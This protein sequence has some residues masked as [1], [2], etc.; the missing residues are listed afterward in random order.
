MQQD[1]ISVIVPCYN[2]EKYIDD[3]FKSLEN[4]TYQNIEVIFVNDGSKDGTF[5]KIKKFCEG[6]KKFRYIDKP[7]GGVGSA[8]NVGISEAKGKF[9]YFCD[10]DDMLATNI[11]SNLVSN[12]KES[13]ADVSICKFKW[14]GENK[15]YKK[16]ALSSKYKNFEGKDNMMSQLYCGKKFAF[17]LC[18]KLFR[19]EKIKKLENFPNVFNTK[20]TY[21]EDTEFL[22]KYFSIINKA[23]YTPA[24]LY[25]YRQ[26]KGSL[27]HSKFN[28]SKLSV[29]NCLDFAESLDKNVFQKSQVYF[30]SRR[31]VND[32]DI[33]F[34][35]S[36]TDYDNKEKISNL[37]CDF[38]KN[39]K[40]LFKGS[41]NP[42]YLWFLPLTIP[43]LKIKLKKRLDKE[44]LKKYSDEKFINKKHRNW[45]GTIMMA[46]FRIFPIKKNRIYFS[47]RFGS[48][49][50][51]NPRAMFEYIYKNHKNEFDFY[52]CLNK[53]DENLP[54]DVKRGKY[55][56]FKD[57]YYFCTA[58]YIITNVRTCMIFAKRRKQV[59]IQ[60]WH[61]IP[62]K[63][64]ERDEKG[65]KRANLWNSV[66]DSNV[67]DILPVGSKQSQDILD[68]CFMCDHKTMLTGSP[69]NDQLILQDKTKIEDIK[70]KIGIGDEYVVLYAP[71]FRRNQKVEESVFDN[72]KVKK[73]FEKAVGRKIKIL[74]RFHPVVAKEGRK[75]EFEDYVINVTDYPDMQE[76][77][78]ISDIL[79]TDF[80]SCMF[81]M[82]LTKKP[83][84]IFS[85]D[86]EKYLSQERG[87]YFSLKL[88]PF[89]IA[90]DQ[91]GLIDLVNNFDKTFESYEAKVEKYLSDNGNVEDGH[92][93]ERLYNAMIRIGKEK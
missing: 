89:P 12:L 10:S 85:N 38:K 11:I 55:L 33:L 52:Y 37:Y 29:F 15:H 25:F 61:G 54:K 31:C 46:I 59:Y 81:D 17:G 43:Y 93:C 78:L 73:A 71:T 57:T 40:Y 74:Y 56:S 32:F 14:V 27:V 6:K 44:I 77:L 62:L 75:L 53:P 84:I 92:S 45:V 39:L 41:K 18:N 16:K 50:S 19:L 4:Q 47:T 34:R 1:L 70:K 2:V 13:K 64:I 5:D 26:R 79:I 91:K 60:T 23:C 67:I 49:F 66:L 51:C 20:A 3:C 80:S 82:M 48:S 72:A 65:I 8:R 7:N 88:L 63:M 76:L 30:K 21:G 90:N 36:K 69:R 86:A 24:K 87:T 22:T 68:R 9:I 58:K 83:C 42:K 35:I 28:E